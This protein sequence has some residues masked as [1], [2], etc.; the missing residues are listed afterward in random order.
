MNH[1]IQK[2]RNNN[3]GTLHLIAALFVMYGHHCALLEQAS[4]LLFNCRIQSIGV[5]T[6]FLISGYLITKSLW[7]IKASRLKTGIIYTVKRFGRLYPEYIVCIL[8]TTFIIGPAFTEVARDVYWNDVASIRLYITSNLLLFPVYWLPGVFASNRY[9]NAINGSFW[10][11][12][13]EIALYFII[14]LAFLVSK[15]DSIRKYTYTL[16]STGLIL[17]FLIRFA[18]FPYEA[19]V[20]HGTDWLQALNVMPYFLIGGLAWLYNWKRYLN[21]TV[22]AVLLFIFASGTTRNVELADEILCLIVLSYFVLSMMLESEQKL[23]LNYVK[24]EYA[25]GMYLYGFVIQQCIVKIMLSDVE[26]TFL[27][28]HI[29]FAVSVFITYCLASISYKWVYIPSNILV[30]KI[31]NI[32]SEQA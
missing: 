30:N 12:P 22:G 19:L 25:Y 11:M 32:L 4:A 3:I 9:A 10:T 17:L 31:L 8:F 1:A 7:N 23:S 15:R 28:F 29:T 14:L 24:S 27:N 20:W 5:K 6:I 26:V 16:I 2:K 18:F 21:P 13:V